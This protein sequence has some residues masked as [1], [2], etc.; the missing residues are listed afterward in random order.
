[1]K[2]SL[3]SYLSYI[4]VNKRHTVSQKTWVSNYEAVGHGGTLRCNCVCG[5]L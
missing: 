1:M 4:L 3:E 5:N 2:Q